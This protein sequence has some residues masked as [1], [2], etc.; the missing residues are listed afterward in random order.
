MIVG[1]GARTQGSAMGQLGGDLGRTFGAGTRKQLGI[2]M[3]RQSK[4][5]MT[6]QLRMDNLRQATEDRV[7]QLGPNKTRQ[8]DSGSMSGLLGSVGGT[9]LGSVNQYK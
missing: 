8:L 5:E 2:D 3:G 6:R 1:L 7:R 4:D 9:K